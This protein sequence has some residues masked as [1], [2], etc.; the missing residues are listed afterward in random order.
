MKVI[1]V[2]FPWQ[3]KKI[4][5]NKDYHDYTILSADSE[6][7]YILKKNN[8]RY[9]DIHEFC[10]QENLWKKYKHITDNSLKITKIL[11]KYLWKFDN[12]FKDLQWNLFDD[13]HFVFKRSYEQLYYYAE[14]TSKL[15]ERFNPSQI[16][17]ADTENIKFTQQMLVD[18]NISLFKFL[19]HNLKE[20]D[21]KIEIKYMREN[22]ETIPGKFTNNFYKKF[23]NKVLIKKKL[24]NFYYKLDFYFNYFLTKPQYF[25]VGCFEIDY[26]KKLYPQESKRY[27]CY[28]H[29][30]INYANSKDE[31]KYFNDFCKELNSDRE[32]KIFTN[33][34]EI[35]FNNLF[36]EIVL[37]LSKSFDN[38]I[39]KYYKVKKIIEKTRPKCLIFRTMTPYESSNFIFRKICKDLKL[40]YVTWIHGGLHSYSLSGYDVTDFRFC[41]NHI[42]YGIHLDE[43][44]ND[45]KS[46]LNKLNLQ[47]NH[48]V[49]PVGSLRFDYFI[50]KKKSK[51]ILKKNNKFTI[52][53]TIGW[54]DLRNNYSLGTNS[55]KISVKSA[56]KFQYQIIK[57]L[58]KYQHKYNIIVKDYPNPPNGNL[59]KSILRDLNAKNITYVSNQFSFTNLLHISDLNILPWT[60]TT[61][62]ESLYFDADIFCINE[63]IDIN[64]F[65][66]KLK[67]ELFY[68]NNTTEYI[69]ELDKYLEQGNFYKKKKE[70]SRD[71][72]INFK[73]LHKRDKLLSQALSQIIQE[74]K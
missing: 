13:L 25:S 37:Q 14:S 5:E 60:S 40:P 28:N 73:N 41:Q 38:F 16:T 74:R 4:C 10:N 33:Y 24:R 22:S 17:V 15:I 26:F 71:Y 64:L 68:F 43:I 63:I 57:L 34:R 48:K 29:E 9:F 58:Q 11:D 70:N 36:F 6:A 61:F 66:D 20:S 42:S 69:K 53:Y 21:K 39:K 8:H 47:K 51:K 49:Y 72:F 3:A 18:S 67:N 35:N 59:W 52:L 55:K 32:F 45:E 27:I 54:A 19:F 12:R 46:I 23:F 7:S 1:L 50:K 56:W 30:D 62:F 2:E 44:I 31:W 65:K